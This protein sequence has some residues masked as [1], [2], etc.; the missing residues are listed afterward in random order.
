MAE[1]EKRIS[2]G[3]TLGSS[4]NEHSTLSSAGPPRQFR[5][6]MLAT[7]CAAGS[8][9]TMLAI[10]GMALMMRARGTIPPLTSDDLAAAER[11]WEEH[12]PADYDLEVDIAGRQSGRFRVEVRAGKTIH[13]TRNGVPPQRR[14]WDTWTV[15][16]MFDT[17]HQ[18]LD[19]AAQ[20]G[21]AFGQPGA[22]AV[23]RAVFDD[24]LGYPRQY[25]RFVMGT[26]YEIRWEVTHFEAAGD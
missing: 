11:L 5:A 18:E 7:G 1:Q 16:G 9:V 12:G 10:V 13:V 26:V 25:E 6:S 15:P 20:A 4:A 14:T 23:E 21:G 17:L 24:Q 3:E 19:L 22:E 2:N 8:L